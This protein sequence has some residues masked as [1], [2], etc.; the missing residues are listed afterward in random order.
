ME[1][2]SE[3]L[4]VS[5]LPTRSPQSAHLVH[6]PTILEAKRSRLPAGAR[7]FL[8]EYRE[9][10]TQV[11]QAVKQM[12]GRSIHWTSFRQGS[13]ATTRAGRA[14]WPQRGNVRGWHYRSSQF[15]SH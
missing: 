2:C 9:D 12:I 4:S 13:D 6:Q 1:P 14:V 7:Q 10:R 3:E 5:A 11:M 8:S 15:A